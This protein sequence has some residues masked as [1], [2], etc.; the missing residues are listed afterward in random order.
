MRP[1]TLC[2]PV[3]GGPVEK[4]LLGMKKTGFGRG[5]YN[6]FGGKIEP[7]EAEKAAAVRELYEESG[8]MTAEKD[9]RLAGS[10][11]FIFPDAPELNHTVAIFFVDTWQGQPK[12]TEE[13]QP[14]WFY[15]ENIPYEKMWADDIYWLPKVLSGQFAEGQVIFAEDNEKIAKIDIVFR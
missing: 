5:K 6:G 8:L 3:L 11:E 12:E 10:L 14:V 1:T 7:G 13:M 9:L 2:L 4:I 15:V